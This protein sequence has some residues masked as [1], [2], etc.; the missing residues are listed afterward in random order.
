MSEKFNFKIYILLYY[1]D[2]KRKD[3]NKK[4]NKNDENITML[5]C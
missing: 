4:S 3:L 1:L 5:V 2:Q